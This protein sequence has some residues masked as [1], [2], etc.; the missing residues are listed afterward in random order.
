MKK[1]YFL[2]F[3]CCFMSIGLSAQLDNRKIK[4]TNAKNPANSVP[5]VKIKNDGLKIPVL[6][7]KA[8][9]PKLKNPKFIK[10]GENVYID[11]QAV[12]DE[13]TTQEWLITPGKSNDRGVCIK[14][15]AV[16]F[17]RDQGSFEFGHSLN[18]RN[19]Y[20]YLECYFPSNEKGT[21]LVEIT[22]IKSSHSPN[23]EVEVKPHMSGYQ[24]TLNFSVYLN[25]DAP[26]VRFFMEKNNAGE[27]TFK[28]TNTWDSKH[29]FKIRNIRIIKTNLSIE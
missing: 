5:N 22:F 8:E 13:F 16:V 15:D 23:V 3:L 25:T 27:E 26:K 11:Q 24:G 4:N 18:G 2:L 21:Y 1:N 6:L 12:A 10:E 28:I 19:D 20:N 17:A 9:A 29:K 7:P 14:T